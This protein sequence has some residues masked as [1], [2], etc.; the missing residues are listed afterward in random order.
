MS[1]AAV[2]HGLPAAVFPRLLQDLSYYS[3]PKA[4]EKKKSLDE[5]RRCRRGSRE[6]L[7]WTARQ[8]RCL[9][10]RDMR[11]GNRQLVSRKRVVA[12]QPA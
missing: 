4:L 7:G 1:H 3:A 9:L 12:C 10:A 2:A 5:A 6:G 11:A 8:Q